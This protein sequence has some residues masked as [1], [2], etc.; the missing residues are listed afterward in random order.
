MTQKLDT[1]AEA[2]ERECRN[3]HDAITG[4]MIPA[5]YGVRWQ[6]MLRAL[7]AE[8]DH[9]KARAERVEA[10]VQKMAAQKKS[11]EMEYPMNAEWEQG[12]NYAIT[13]ARVTLAQ[14]DAEPVEPGITLADA[15]RAGRDAAAEKAEKKLGKKRLYDIQ[16]SILDAISA[17]EVPDDFGGE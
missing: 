11:N 16:Q 14:I 8:R 2:V 17:L 10:Y 13:D 15:Y 7:A 6:S 1:S 3:I 4:K 9:Y 5:V 12:F